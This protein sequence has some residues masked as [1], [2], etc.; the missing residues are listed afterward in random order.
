MSIIQ[1]LRGGRDNDPEF[2][3]RMSG[4][5]PYA[6]LIRR[7]FSVACRRL[8][9]ESARDRELVTALFQPPRPASPQMELAL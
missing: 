2:G 4:I 1:S 9:I 5:G 3:T 8:G 7:R 6:E